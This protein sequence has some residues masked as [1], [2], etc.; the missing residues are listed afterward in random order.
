[1]KILFFSPYFYPYT[2]GLTNYPWK[3]LNYLGK[4]HQIKVLTFNHQKTVIP[5]LTRNPYKIDSRLRG[6]DIIYIPYLFKISK[7]YISPQSLF[8]FLKEIKNA[9]LVFLNLPSVEGLPLLL[10]AKIFRKKTISLLHCFL[11]GGKNIFEK[12]IFKVANFFVY[13]QLL[14]SDKIVAYTKDYLKKYFIFNL[15]KNKTYFHLPP[16][17]KTQED[18]KYINFLKKLTN[19]KI[20]IGYAGRISSEK[21]LEYLI[22]SIKR[23]TLHVT[24]YTLL[25]A[26]P[27]GKEVAGEEKYFL[28]IKKLLDKNK[29]DYHFLG[30]LIP[31]KL[32]AFYKAIDVLVLPSIN[33][34]EAFGM[35][36]AEAM[37]SGTPVIATNLPG[38]NI[39]I[40]LTKMGIIVEPKNEKQIHQAI[41]KIIK[42]RK[43]YTN[44]KLVANAN[45]IFDINKVYKFWEQIIF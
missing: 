35:V 33:S 40:N 32:F 19:K 1:M 21:G 28:K 27:F 9:D 24:R 5:G 44:K 29:I 43:K 20:V 12:I 23:Y 11:N 13:F 17:L 26:G 36:Q 42:N 4:K 18:K 25:F 34:T 10:L 8:Y 30:T 6:N 37:I 16:I 38:V 39:P 22:S 3:I 15:I 45:K 41:L 31:E 2:S 14:L 7:G